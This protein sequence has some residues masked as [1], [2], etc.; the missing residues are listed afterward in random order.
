[1]IK[2]RM[3]AS[4]GIGGTNH[5]DDVLMVKSLLN[6]HARSDAGR[7]TLPMTAQG[8]SQLGD[9]IREF[10]T[11]TMG[12][13]KP[14]GQV[15]ANAGTFK[16]LLTLLRQTNRI[17]SS[18]APAQGRLTWDAEGAEGGPFHSRR[19]HVPSEW[20]GLTIGRGYDM[21]FKNAGLILG[22]LSSI[23]IA[24][25]KATLLSQASALR[26]RR[27]ASFIYQSDL[28]DFEITPQQQSLL[29]SQTYAAEFAEV[30]RISAEP[31]NVNRYGS[32]D[33]STLPQAVIDL[34]VDLKYRGDYTPE[35]RKLLQASVAIGDYGAFKAVIQDASLWRSVPADRFRRRS[36]FA[37]TIALAAAIT[38]P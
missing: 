5:A 4:V 13:A 25:E 26:G 11:V 12:M 1:M 2:L 8:D 23:G 19:L 21:Q 36:V 17:I 7:P 15:S 10:Q 28:L 35:S 16:Q 20:S 29:F 9:R 24:P 14:D 31:Q 6:A 32:I 22:T 34:M 38:T 33:W 37:E 18:P 3:Q 27:A 30:R